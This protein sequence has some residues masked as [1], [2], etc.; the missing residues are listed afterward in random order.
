MTIIDIILRW[1]VR[2][3][4]A[5][6]L[7]ILCALLFETFT[8]KPFQF[9]R[10]G[11][12]LLFGGASIISGLALG[13]WSNVATDGQSRKFYILTAL[14]I[15]LLVTLGIGVYGFVSMFD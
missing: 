11:M 1:L 12:P 8:R 5:V 6:S 14:S 4:L 15:S 3:S 13:S 9:P 2:L 10:V 7:L